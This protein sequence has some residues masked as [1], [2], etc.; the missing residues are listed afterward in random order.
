N[1]IM[2]VDFALAAGRQERLSSKDSIRRAAQLRARPIIMTTLAASLSAIPLAIGVGPGHELR[3]PLVIAIVGG[4]LTSQIL[5]LYTTPVIYLVI[6][7]LRSRRRQS[8]Q[9]IPSMKDSACA[10]RGELS[11]PTGSSQM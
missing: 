6:D 9:R 7:R 2:V 10:R 3:Q 11:L 1:A 4:L 5:T 8:A